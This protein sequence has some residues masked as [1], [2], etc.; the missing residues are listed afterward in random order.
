MNAS[1]FMVIHPLFYGIG[2]DTNN[3]AIEHECTKQENKT[4]SYQH[5]A[6]YMGAITTHIEVIQRIRVC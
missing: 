2:D 3:D 5:P 4:T 1:L 6:M